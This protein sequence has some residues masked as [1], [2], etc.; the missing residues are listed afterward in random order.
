MLPISEKSIVALMEHGD[1]WCLD[2]DT[3]AT[4]LANGERTRTPRIPKVS[5]SV[6]VIPLQGVITKRGGF[7]SDGLDRVSRVLET[8][9]DS[10]AIGGV[11]LDVDSPGG[12]IYG[13]VEFADKLHSFRDDSKPLLAVANPLA[14]S[15]AF[16]AASAADQFIASPSADVGSVGVWS[17]HLDLSQFYQEKMKVKPTLVSAGKYKVEGNP[18]EPLSDE[19]RAEIQRSVDEA[20]DKFLVSLAKNRGVSK[21]QVQSNFGEGRVLSAERAKAAGMVDRVMPLDDVVKAMSV[22][23]KPRNGRRA[24]MEHAERHLVAAWEDKPM[25]DVTAGTYVNTRKLRRE[26]QRRVQRFGA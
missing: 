1:L 21:T 8:A 10:K 5:G 26:R 9:M 7:F 19:A 16:W 4:H 24:E 14:A 20:Y 22:N 13:L 15:A 23:D 17:L 18:F 3:L 6:A 25:D 2:I 12:S 11:V